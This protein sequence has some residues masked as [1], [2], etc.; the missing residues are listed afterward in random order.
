M[1]WI[2]CLFAYDEIVDMLEVG[3]H[4]GMD[5]YIYALVLLL[6]LLCSSSI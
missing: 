4:G 1:H 2:L 6:N 5:Q 3:S